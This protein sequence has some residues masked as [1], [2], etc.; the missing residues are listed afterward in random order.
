MGTLKSL[1]L[2]VG[3]QEQGV[4]FTQNLVRKANLSPTEDLLSLRPSVELQS[5]LCAP[6]P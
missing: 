6:V 1:A 3:A 5:L 4:S 2:Q